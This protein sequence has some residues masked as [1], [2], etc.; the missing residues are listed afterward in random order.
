MLRNWFIAL[1]L[2]LAVATGSAQVRITTPAGTSGGAAGAP[3]DGT[4]FITDVVITKADPLVQFQPA[5]ATDTPWWGGVCDDAG[6]DDDD[7]F[8]V[9]DEATPCGAN[10]ALL[11]LI[12]TTNIRGMRLYPR[13]DQGS[14][15]FQIQHSFDNVVN[16]GLAGANGQVLIIGNTGNSASCINFSMQ[17]TTRWT[18]D[19]TG[20]FELRPDVNATYDIGSR[21]KAVREVV[22][23]SVT[24]IPT[25][26]KPTCAVGERGR[27]WYTQGGGGAADAMEVCAK[28][29]GDA[30]AWRAFTIA[31]L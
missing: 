22:S 29:A 15:Y 10:P 5:T 31:G 30:Y 18:F 26:A 16:L 19:C 2:L 9:T 27:I 7:R 20:D 21:T 11:Q 17:S 13:A 1:V 6:T 14:W 12:P 4:D 3:T 28:D 8:L 23:E 24:L 25:N